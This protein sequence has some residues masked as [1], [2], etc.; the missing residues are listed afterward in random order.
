MKFFFDSKKF[1]VTLQVSLIKVEGEEVFQI[2]SLFLQMILILG[3]HNL[4][5][6]LLILIAGLVKIIL[7]PK[8]ATSRKLF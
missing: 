5:Y 6:V 2:W 3:L 4:G 1:E 8:S 7:K